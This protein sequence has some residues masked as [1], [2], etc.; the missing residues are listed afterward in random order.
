MVTIL[1]ANLALSVSCTFLKKKRD[2][3]NGI[4][5]TKQQQAG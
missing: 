4:I 5:T 3:L 2:F 1:R